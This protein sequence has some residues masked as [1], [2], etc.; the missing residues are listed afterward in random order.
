MIPKTWTKVKMYNNWASAT[1]VAGGP[2]QKHLDDTLHYV[3]LF[4]VSLRVPTLRNS[5]VLSEAPK[6]DT[7]HEG[8]GE[9]GHACE[10]D[11]RV[12]H[13]LDL[14]RY[15]RACKVTSRR[16][17]TIRYHKRDATKLQPW[18]FYT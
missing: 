7:H 8:E 16:G 5:F 10:F 11:T 1:E 17:E 13:S 4:Y 3:S 18:L 12:D 14:C 2:D 9:V 6:W 15:G